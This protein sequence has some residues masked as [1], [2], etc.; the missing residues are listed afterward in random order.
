MRE[1][2]GRAKIGYENLNLSPNDM[3]L[4]IG[5]SMGWLD[6]KLIDAS[7]KNVYA[8]D[9]NEESIKEAAKNLNG[10]HFALGSATNLPFKDEIFDKVSL[11]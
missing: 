5:C 9:I 1:I 8:I 10:A 7:M 3:F 4:D 6:R 11:I 2:R